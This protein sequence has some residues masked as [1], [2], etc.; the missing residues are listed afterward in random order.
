MSMFDLVKK[1]GKILFKKR[2]DFE[3]YL[4]TLPDGPYLLEI[5]NLESQRSKAQ[6]RLYR[7]WL[8]L[9]AKEIGV[10]VEYL[11]AVVK[12]NFL[13]EAEGADPIG[14]GSIKYSRSTKDLTVEEMGIYLEKIRALCI[15]YCGFDPK[16]LEAMP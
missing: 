10:S 8:A 1:D 9:M 4:D 16:T 14:G 13:G 7:H 15:N 6:N 3:K 5:L 2:E 11:E 12:K